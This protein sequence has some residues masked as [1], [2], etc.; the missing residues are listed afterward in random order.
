M[1]CTKIE[2]KSVVCMEMYLVV[3]NVHVLN[4]NEICDRTNRKNS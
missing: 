3:I 4:V 2:T 1:L